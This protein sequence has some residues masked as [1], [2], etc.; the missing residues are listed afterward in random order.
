[1][2]TTAKILI[3]A[4]PH[5]VKTTVFVLQ[6]ET[7]LILVIV[8]ELVSMELP[9]STPILAMQIHVKIPLLAHQSKT[10]TLVPVQDQSSMEPTANST[11]LA[12]TILLVKTVELAISTETAILAVAQLTIMGTIAN[13]SI[14]VLQIL[15]NPAVQILA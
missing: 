6:Q 1:M 15:V 2:E 12:T 3:L 4:V 10:L 9:V 13:L 7:T 8:P 14:P 5:L 11:I